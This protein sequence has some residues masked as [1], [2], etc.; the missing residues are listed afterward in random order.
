MAA[1]FAAVAM[2]RL[3]MAKA[4]AVATVI[5][6]VA[7]LVTRVARATLCITLGWCMVVHAACDTR[8]RSAANTGPHHGA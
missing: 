8:A 2:V 4:F 5:T 7:G 6:A 3:V 1:A